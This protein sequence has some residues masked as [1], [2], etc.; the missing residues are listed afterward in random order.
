VWLHDLIKKTLS[1]SLSHSPIL[2]ACKG[3]WI[4]HLSTKGIARFGYYE[5]EHYRVMYDFMAN[6][7][8]MLNF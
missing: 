8:R 6:P 7:Q 1:L 4:Y 3:A 2:M 5:T